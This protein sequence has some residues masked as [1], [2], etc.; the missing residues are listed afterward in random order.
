MTCPLCQQPLCRG[1]GVQAHLMVCPCNHSF[2]LRF[3]RQQN[4]LELVVEFDV[5]DRPRVHKGD[6]FLVPVYHEE[7]PVPVC[8]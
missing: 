7:T 5:A 1:K 6:R 8:H 2:R 4:S 3:F